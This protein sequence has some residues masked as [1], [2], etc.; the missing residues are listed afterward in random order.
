MPHALSVRYLSIP[1]ILDHQLFGIPFVGADICGFNNP[2]TEELCGRWMELGAFYPFARNHNTFGAPPQEPYRWPSVA[3]ISR[4]VLAIRYS[5]LPYY[6]TQFYWANQQGGMVWRP[7][8][9]EFPTDTNAVNI[10]TQFLVGEALL[11]SPALN[12]GQQAVEAYF[13]AALWYDFR[14]G[15]VVQSD[16]AAGNVTVPADFYTIPIHVRGGYVLP[17][18]QPA[19]TTYETRLNPFELLVPLDINGNAAGQLYWDDGISL[20]VGSNYLLVTYTAS[21]LESSHAGKIVS[22]GTFGFTSSVPP[23]QTIT[24]YGVG[25]VAPQQAMLNNKP[26][27]SSQFSFNV[28]S[29]VILFTNLNIPMTSPFGLSWQ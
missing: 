27:A 10:D 17:M 8:I 12:Q 11:I 21:Y 15:V 20:N 3:Q 1:G 25:T 6:Y 22:T 29:N 7:L 18:Q 13:P 2:T 23:L 9:F 14:T 5:L 24:V 16:G 28:T 19:L 4:N 26:L